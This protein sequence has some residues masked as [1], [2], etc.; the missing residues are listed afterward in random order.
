MDDFKKIQIRHMTKAYFLAE[1]FLKT[2]REQVQKPI[3][4]CFEIFATGGC[5]QPNHI[6]KL[7]KVLNE[8]LPKDEG[9]LFK[10]DDNYKW[11]VWRRT[12]KEFLKEIKE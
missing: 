4:K 2:R 5:L 7:E 9:K 11:R 10:W 3:L 12:A 6:A 1:Y 8:N